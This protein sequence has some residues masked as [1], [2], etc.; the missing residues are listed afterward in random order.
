[1]SNTYRYI[2]HAFS[3]YACSI[4]VLLLASLVFQS[5]PGFVWLS[6]LSLMGRN[7][8]ADMWLFA[9][10]VTWILL[11]ILIWVWRTSKSVHFLY[12]FTAEWLLRCGEYVCT[13]CWSQ[14]LVP[15]FLI[16]P[17]LHASLTLYGKGLCCLSEKNQDKF[18][19]QQACETSFAWDMNNC[20][21]VPCF[22]A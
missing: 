15:C 1:M 13:H 18:D 11:C 4:S 21:L 9:V 3:P 6:S 12:W 19:Y 14:F 16:S 8:D 5:I 22:H 7:T 10:R 2:F 17:A 20:T